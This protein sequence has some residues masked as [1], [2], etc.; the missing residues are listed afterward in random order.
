MRLEFHRQVTSDISRIMDYYEDVAGQQL[1][2]DF[3]TEL[4][5]SFQKASESPE[6]YNVRAH[7]S[8]AQADWP[9]TQPVA[10]MSPTGS[11]IEFDGLRQ[12][13]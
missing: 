5:L 8:T 1:A 6:S 9:L 13:A 10:S 3:Y 4:R 11:T 7:D 12:R 2:E